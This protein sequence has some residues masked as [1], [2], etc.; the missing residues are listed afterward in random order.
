MAGDAIGDG[1]TRC[2]RWPSPLAAGFVAC[3]RSSTRAFFAVLH[4]PQREIQRPNHMPVFRTLGP[5]TG[6]TALPPCRAYLAW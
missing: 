5:S 2:A 6:Q 3:P 1:A 4:A